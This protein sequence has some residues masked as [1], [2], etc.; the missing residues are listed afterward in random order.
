MFKKLT[1][2]HLEAFISRYATG[3]RT[4]DVGSGGSSYDRYFPNRL[5][6]DVDPG[7][8]PEIVGDAHALPFG[9][10]EFSHVLCTEVLEHTERPHVVAQELMRVLKPGGTLVLT[11]RFVYPIHDSPGD[12]FRFTKYGLRKLFSEW[13]IIEERAELGDFSTI[14]ALMQRI[15]FQADL[16]GG[17]LSKLV[18]YSLA[19][20]FSKL[21]GLIKKEY[22]DINKSVVDSNILSTGVYIA[23]RK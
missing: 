17:K 18:L 7:R 9:D 6:I 5:T 1:R 19:W 22:G 23:V 16:H 15:G 12:Y 11:T 4:L 14:A 20:I 2:P 10:N 21:D 3:E 8:K 13:T